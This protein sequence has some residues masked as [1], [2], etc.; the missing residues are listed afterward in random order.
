MEDKLDY[1]IL[2]CSGAVSYLIL[3]DMYN[4]IETFNRELQEIVEEYDNEEEEESYEEPE[5]IE[6]TELVDKKSS[7][8]RW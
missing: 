2:L 1:L 7:W 3:K 8:F 6:E 4:N 5:P